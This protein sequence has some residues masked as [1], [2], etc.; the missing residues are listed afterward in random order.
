M[1]HDW[2]KA[3]FVLQSKLPFCGIVHIFRCFPFAPIRF[4]C[5]ETPLRS[6]P[7]RQLSRVVFPAPIGKT[8]SVGNVAVKLVFVIVIR[9]IC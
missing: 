4:M 5:P 8:M 2:H 3:L 6:L 1:E 9:S 7:V